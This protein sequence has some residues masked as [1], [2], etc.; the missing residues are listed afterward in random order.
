MTDLEYV[1]PDCQ[2]GLNLVDSRLTCVRC[3]E[4]FP[5]IDGVADFGK[6]T[7]V[8][9][10]DAGDSLDE[11]QLAGLH[12]EIAGSMYRAEGF[13]LPLMRSSLRLPERDWRVLD[14]GCGNG[15]TVDW[16]NAKGISAWGV[17]L[18]ALRKWQWRD[19]SFKER[20]AVSDVMHLPFPDSKFDAVI[21][22]GVV[23][24][25]GVREWRSP[26]YGVSR[27]G[28]RDD[29]RKGFLAEVWRILA[30]GGIAWLDFPNG[31]FPIDFWHSTKVGRPRWHS[32]DEGFLPRPDELTKY[33]DGLEGVQSRIL[34]PHRRFLFR[35]AG[36]TWYG[37]ILSGPL[38]LFFW[39]CTFRPFEFLL[40]TGLNPY[41]VIELRKP[42][43]EATAAS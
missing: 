24:H 40:R 41:L 42:S 21:A 36:G 23:E 38:R 8:D 29:V 25:L 14:C 18:S 11:N 37:R 20:L 7:Y 17:D 10:F 32:L 3:W 34:S 13:F 43:R 35:Q 1:C 31:A 9:T 39:L 28:D 6:G 26:E 16:L 4:S 19:R 2:G 5:V 30:P 12:G 22:S 15:I 33:L 27:N